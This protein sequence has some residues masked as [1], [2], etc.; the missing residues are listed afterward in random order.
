[1]AKRAPEAK[2][3][4]FFLEERENY[5][6]KIGAAHHGKGLHNFVSAAQCNTSYQLIATH[7][8]GNAPFP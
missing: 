5:I 8:T 2:R 1:M 7:F 6:P 3:R 4:R